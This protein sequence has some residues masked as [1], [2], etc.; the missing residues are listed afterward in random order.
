MSYGAEVAVCSKINTKHTNTLCVCGQNVELLNVKLLVLY[1]TLG[2]KRLIKDRT[3]R[4]FHIYLRELD[5]NKFTFPLD[6]FF[7]WAG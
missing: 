6:H 4:P 7:T 2:F 5:R 1:V 3:T